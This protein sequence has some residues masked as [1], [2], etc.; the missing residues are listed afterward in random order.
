MILKTAISVVGLL[1][2]LQGSAQILSEKEF[3][4]NDGEKVWIRTG[5]QIRDYIIKD[6]NFRK[7]GFEIIPELISM[8]VDTTQI[9]NEHR[10]H[11]SS[12]I[13]TIPRGEI[14]ARY[15][16]K[17]INPSFPALWIKE[18]GKETILSESELE[19]IAA[20]YQQYWEGVRDMSRRKIRRM[21]KQNPPL[22]HSKYS[23]VVE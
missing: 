16:E 13:E 17:I 19:E 4:I 7:I 3:P 12:K 20:L 9:I 11:Y 22:S 8:I 18:T 5:P 6:I 2:T 15:V 1:I 21:W 10:P 14:C 23:W